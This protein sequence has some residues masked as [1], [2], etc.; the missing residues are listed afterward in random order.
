MYV[1]DC[2]YVANRHVSLWFLSFVY[3]HLKI[4]V[5]RARK[6]L[7]WITT[8]WS[9]SGTARSGPISLSKRYM[10]CESCCSLSI[11]TRRLQWGK[12]WAIYDIATSAITK[13][14]PSISRLGFPCSVFGC[15]STNLVNFHILYKNI[16]WCSKK[17]F[18][19]LPLQFIKSL[20]CNL[21]M[22]TSQKSDNIK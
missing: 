9:P 21:H 13:N 6:I 1:S 17:L 14:Y 5:N 2:S 15:S 10:V 8:Q 16:L 18:L 11:F 19:Q 7:P 12:K 20:I 4:V 22:S 3:S